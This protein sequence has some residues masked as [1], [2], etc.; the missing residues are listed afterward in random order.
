MLGKKVWF[1]MNKDGS[2]RKTGI[3]TKDNYEGYYEV[4]ETES[5]KVYLTVE[6]E[7]ELING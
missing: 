5:G 3:V 4:T 1:W 7:M 2:Y 6:S